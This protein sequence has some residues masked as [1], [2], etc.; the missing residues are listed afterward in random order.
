M[1]ENNLKDS[2]PGYTGH[3]KTNEEEEYLPGK[4]EAKKQIPGMITTKHN[5]AAPH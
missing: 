4:S 5:T 1:F 3:L 2:I